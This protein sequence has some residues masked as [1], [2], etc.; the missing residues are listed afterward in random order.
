MYTA[1]LSSSEVGSESAVMD[2]EAANIFHF[3][4]MVWVT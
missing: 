3:I 4:C 1:T 2:S